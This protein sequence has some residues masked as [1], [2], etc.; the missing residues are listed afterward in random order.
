M[1]Q[2]R[3]LGRGLGALIPGAGSAPAPEQELRTRSTVR[4]RSDQE[5]QSVSERPVD[6]FFSG[7]EISEEARR[8]RDRGPRQDLAGDMA[9]DA[10]KRRGRDRKSTRLNSSHVAISYAG[11]CLI[12]K[13]RTAIGIVIR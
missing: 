3:G 1:T 13:N 10:A 2:K 11:F 5:E 12:K 9:R 7:E 8:Q 6:M 4:T